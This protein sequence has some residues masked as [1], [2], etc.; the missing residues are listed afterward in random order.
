MVAAFGA[1]LAVTL[2]AIGV[3][4]A[5]G[6]TTAS[7]RYPWLD[8]WAGRLPYISAAILLV[9]GSA[10][11]ANGVLAFSTQHSIGG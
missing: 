5:W 2:V 4:A 7:D 3:I 8:Q 10:V 6:A 9:I 1:G 11:L